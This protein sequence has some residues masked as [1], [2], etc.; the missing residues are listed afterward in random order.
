MAAKTFDPK[1]LVMNCGGNNVTGYADGTFVKV[2]RDE[3]AFSFT[4]G[5]DGEGVRA[6]SNVKSATVTFTLLQS[7]AANDI[8][9]AFALA[10]ELNNGGLFPLLIKDN[11]GRSLFAAESAWVQKMADSEFSGDVTN[12]EWVVRTDS[13]QV[14]VGGL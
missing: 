2:E 10:D 14:L 13:L 3:D 1:K 7:S 12:R 8:F 4:A 11:N 9:S 6:K 5:A